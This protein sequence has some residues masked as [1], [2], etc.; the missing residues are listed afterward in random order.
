[1][2]TRS[3]L[4][5]S[6]VLLSNGSKFGR[7]EQLESDNGLFYALMQQDGDF[8][9]YYRPTARIQTYQIF[10]TGPR[11]PMGNG[12]FFLRLD[13]DGKLVLYRGT[14]SKPVAPAL[15]SSPPVDYTSDYFVILQND[16]NLCI[17]RG[18]GPGDNKGFVWQAG[19]A[20]YDQGS[21]LLI[22]G[23]EGFGNM[24]VSGTSPVTIQ[25]KDAN[26]ARQRWQLIERRKSDNTVTYILINESTGMALNGNGFGK[27]VNMTSGPDDW[28]VWMRGGPEYGT[29]GKSAF[30]AF[31]PMADLHL[32]LNV[33]GNN[34]PAGTGLTLWEWKGAQWN[35]VFR[36]RRASLPPATSADIQQDV[37]YNIRS[38][39]TGHYLA[40]EAD[41]FENGARLA[42]STDP[43]V[44]NAQF[45]LPRQGDGPIYLRS[46]NS[47][48]Y[49]YFSGYH[50]EPI[51]QRFIP[52]DRA[53]QLK[54]QPARLANG[55]YRFDVAGVNRVRLAVSEDGAGIGLRETDDDDPLA[56]FQVTVPEKFR[57]PETPGLVRAD[58][59]RG[60]MYVRLIAQG[61]AS[62]AMT[63]VPGGSAIVSAAFMVVWPDRTMFNMLKQLRE[64]ILDEVD[65]RI[66]TSRVS[67]A[68]AKIE[69]L[70]KQ[71]L[72]A[73][74]AEKAQ[75]FRSPSP[76]AT[77]MLQQLALNFA[78]ELA[79]LLPDSI[80]AAP[81]PDDA[82]T[83]N[84]LLSGFPLYVIGAVER[85]SILQERALME[86][87]TE[88]QA[89]TALTYLAS[90]IDDHLKRMK[91]A[92]DFLVV[93]RQRA[94]YLSE[95]SEDPRFSLVQLRDKAMD[96]NPRPELSGRV[97]YS[98]N[99]VNNWDMLAAP[100]KTAYNEHLRYNYYHYKYPYWREA[101]QL[102]GIPA[103][104]KTLRAR[105]T[106]DEAYRELFKKQPQAALAT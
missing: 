84:L 59:D 8:A 74:P 94:V 100:M 67:V 41:S 9:V 71:Y 89:D 77:G 99:G 90:E 102:S 101:E 36:T 81:I 25:K 60:L 53:Q 65:I 104:T 39:V 13:K 72:N 23:V 43:N 47:G 106:S 38:G 26:D 21:H 50:A 70:R 2:P 66:A 83:H 14:P 56:Q 1:M 48:K 92:F 17:Y 63:K 40:I 86:V 10:H 35:L 12:D 7:S 51:T 98:G 45:R 46:R 34:Y 97:L 62:A 78:G 18:T 79:S 76:S 61:L 58:T 22:S 105:L 31:K 32:H 6:Q 52:E 3:F 4:T 69:E 57:A 87:F 96:P 68:A 103:L 29:S 27:P 33:A 19:V 42:F 11:P 49:L 93:K 88:P 82:A 15:W 91:K 95:R 24:V 85:I 44:G 55:Y 80:D 54:L 16:G 20:L 30:T 28:A 5:T 64:D 75:Y 73:Y 37:Y